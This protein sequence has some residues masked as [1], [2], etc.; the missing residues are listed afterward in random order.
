MYFSIAKKI[1]NSHQFRFREKNSVLLLFDFKTSKHLNSLIKKFRV[2]F[3]HSRGSEKN[4]T[5]SRKRRFK[6]ISVPFLKNRYYRS[7]NIFYSVI[8][9]E[10]FQKCVVSKIKG[11]VEFKLA[12]TTVQRK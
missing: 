3:L 7:L 11:S 9:S 12:T 5:F 6:K 4:C 10:S 2:V 8:V 1:M